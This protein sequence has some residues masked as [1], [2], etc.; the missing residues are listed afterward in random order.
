MSEP[1]PTCRI[2]EKYRLIECK[3]PALPWDPQGF[4]ILHSEN[5]EKSP[6][7]FQEAIQARLKQ[8]NVNILD[9]R[10]VWFPVRFDRR[11]YFGKGVDKPMDFSWALFS[12]EAIFS[13]CIFKENVDFLRA[14]FVGEAHFYRAV[15]EKRARFSYTDFGGEADF[16]AA[17]FAEPADFRHAKIQGRMIFKG[18]YEPGKA[19]ASS[20]VF[21]RWGDFRFLELGPEAVLIFQDLSLECVE[22]TGTHLYGV[23]FIMCSGTLI[24]VVRLPLTRYY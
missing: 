22:F 16:Y 21:L 10:G 19:P 20:Q 12:K 4:C 6:V 1:T 14:R 15:F 13:G 5:K 18:G 8:E 9:F 2:H 24:E 17:S 7:F 23:N 11:D 3:N